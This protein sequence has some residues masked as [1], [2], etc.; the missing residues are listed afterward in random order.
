MDTQLLNNLFEKTPVNNVHFFDS[1]GSTNEAAM[2]LISSMDKF[3][4]TLFVADEQT[5]GRGR[6]DRRWFTPRGSA[7]AFTLA[8]KPTESE[9]EKLTLFSPLAGIAVCEAISRIAE[10]VQIKWPNDVLINR[11]KVCGIL[12]ESVWDV[13]RIKGVAVGIGI[14][15]YAGSVPPDT[16]VQFAATSVEQNATKPVDRWMLLKEIVT[17]LYKWRAILGSREFFDNWQRNLAFVGEP[18][19]VVSGHG[20][21]TRG[22]LQGVD[23]E[24][25]LVLNVNGHPQTVTVGDVHLR[26]QN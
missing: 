14:N 4:E 7:L 25:S 1:I 24:G 19:K 5:K 22:F 11:Q 9:A 6:F 8:L 21:E 13:G 10:G 20:E 2:T 23:A 15:I 12:T 18:V 3:A 16:E 26:L 17:S